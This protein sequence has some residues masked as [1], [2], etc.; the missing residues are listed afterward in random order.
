MVAIAAMRRIER[1]YVCGSF[2][3]HPQPLNQEAATPSRVMRRPPSQTFI[4]TML[5][6]NAPSW[7]AITSRTLCE[8]LGVSLQVLANWRVRGVGPDHDRAP[9]GHGNK[10]LY[11][12][13]VVSSWLVDEAVPT[14]EFSAR[15]LDLRGLM[16]PDWSEAGTNE[17]IAWLEGLN[18]FPASLKQMVK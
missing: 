10:M 6:D 11:R 1:S 7:R 4:D 13:D 3:G 12:P 16:I 2:K 15:W 8:R 17:I 9:R 5:A 18:M 14:W